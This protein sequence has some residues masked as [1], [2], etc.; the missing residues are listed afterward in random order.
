MHLKLDEE[1]TA[2]QETVRAFA[3]EQ[4]RPKAREWEEEQ[5]LGQRALDDA[6]RLGFASMGVGPS[7]GGAGDDDNAAPSALSNAIVLE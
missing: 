4:V 1:R 6:W 2:L 7:F 3:K 5:R